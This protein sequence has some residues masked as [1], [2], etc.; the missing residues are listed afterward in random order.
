MSNLHE[1]LRLVREAGYDLSPDMVWL[2]MPGHPMGKVRV[3]AFDSIDSFK[4]FL[5]T[6]VV[7]RLSPA[8]SLPPEGGDR[9]PT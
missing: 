5:E 3:G 9:W 6:A 2:I 1:V 4:R 7:V 8:I